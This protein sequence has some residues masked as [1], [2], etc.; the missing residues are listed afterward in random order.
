MLDFNEFDTFTAE[1]Q[2]GLMLLVP[3]WCRELAGR[4]KWPETIEHRIVLTSML[5]ITGGG[6]E[7]TREAIKEDLECSYVGRHGDVSAWDHLGGFDGLRSMAH[8]HGVRAL[9]YFRHMLLES[10]VDRLK[11]A[12]N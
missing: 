10:H 5:M 1:E 4:A 6:K 3:Y 11:K 8:A 12:G 9:R 7:V 2:I